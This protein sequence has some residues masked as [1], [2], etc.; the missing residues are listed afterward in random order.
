[1]V[2]ERP[3]KGLPEVLQ[4]ESDHEMVVRT[5][6]PP[7]AF[8]TLI[9]SLLSLLFSLLFPYFFKACESMS[10]VPHRLGLRYKKR[11]DQEENSSILSRLL[12]SRSFQSQ[13]LS[14]LLV[15]LFSPI[16]RLFLSFFVPYLVSSSSIS[17][18]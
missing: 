6:T 2:V 4:V 11:N 8:S 10:L 5:G 18:M 3:Q 12:L 1:M 15:S 14:H 13:I 16:F 9:C 7:Q 17:H